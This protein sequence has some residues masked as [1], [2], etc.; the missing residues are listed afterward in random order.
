MSKE[1]TLA[2]TVPGSEQVKR[3]YKNSS[4][5]FDMIEFEFAKKLARPFQ[6]LEEPILPVK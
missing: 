1:G 2:L 3:L 6:Q 4:E 5:V